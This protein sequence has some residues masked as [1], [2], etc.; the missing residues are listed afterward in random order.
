MRKPIAMFATLVFLAIYI[1]G[2]ATLGASMTEWPRVAQLGFYIVAG[3]AWALPLYPL[4]RWM[5]RGGGRA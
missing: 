2:A 5:N 3:L 1:I 4:M